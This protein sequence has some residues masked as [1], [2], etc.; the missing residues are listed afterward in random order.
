MIRIRILADSLE[1]AQTLAHALSE[2]DRLEIVEA[3][4][5]THDPDST[6]ERVADVTLALALSKNDLRALRAPIVVLSDTNAG[7]RFGRTVRAWLPLSSAVAEIEAALV[8]AAQDLFVLT[9]D[10]GRR[11]LRRETGGNEDASIEELTPRE[12][13]V[14]RMLADGLGNKEIAAALHISEHTAKF[15]VSQI[16]AK[17]GVSS[18]AEA[19]AIGM[20]RGLVPI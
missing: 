20:R 17:L 7:E 4:A 6:A 19:V 13:Q 14:L 2:N 10:Q 15:H 16:L 5:L 11:W 18:R 8:A 1:R 9:L 12:L 3:R